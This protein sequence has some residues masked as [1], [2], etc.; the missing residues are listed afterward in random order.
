[1]N[2]PPDL[3]LLISAFAGRV[4]SV[5]HAALVS[6]GGLPL[7]CSDGLP[8]E[9]VDQL[10]AVASGLT[11]LVQGAARLFQ[12]GTAAQTVVIM[13]QGMLI[14]KPVSD[15]MVLAVL[16]APE[17]DLGLVSYEIVLLREQ[18]ARILTR[19]PSASSP[20][21]ASPATTDRMTPR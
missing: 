7:A 14:L 2:P 12:G 9:R 4:P 5:A 1:V 10:A 6:S 3:N 11:S 15:G 13:E 8:A 18:A 19:Q 17:C 16:A 20:A 21:A